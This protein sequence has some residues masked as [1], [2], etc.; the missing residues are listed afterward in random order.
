MNIS[1]E[2]SVG[3]DP[4]EPF[5]VQLLKVETNSKKDQVTF[6][7]IIKH[8]TGSIPEGTVVR[9]PFINTVNAKD[10]TK[11]PIWFDWKPES[12]LF[13]FT[14]EIQPSA[15]SDQV[16]EYL[17]ETVVETPD[18][19]ATLTFKTRMS[20][21]EL[22]P[23]VT[24]ISS[25]I[26]DEV[27]KVVLGVTRDDGRP[28]KRAWVDVSGPGVWHTWDSNLGELTVNIKMDKL[29]GNMV[30]VDVQFPV[31][32]EETK[33][34]TN[35]KVK[36]PVP[37]SRTIR[38][39]VVGGFI[40]K[41][42]LTFVANFRWG[43]TGKPPEKLSIP[44]TLKSATNVPSGSVKVSKVDYNPLTGDLRASIKVN[45]NNLIKMDY[46]LGML[47]TAD[48]FDPHFVSLL[49][50]IPPKQVK[51][52]IA[53][54]TPFFKGETINLPITV[55]SDETGLNVPISL[56][57]DYQRNAFTSRGLGDILSPSVKS[58]EGKTVL[59]WNVRQD[60]SR[61]VE[62]SAL[63]IYSFR[64]NDFLYDMKVVL[65][66]LAIDSIA[67]EI[68][69]ADV[70][71]TLILSRGYPIGTVKLAENKG[72]QYET[73][74]EHLGANV[75]KIT[76]RGAARTLR[77]VKK[78]LGGRLVFASDN[79]RSIIFSDEVE[80]FLK[81]GEGELTSTPVMSKLV[82]DNTLGVTTKLQWED[83][84]HPI[85][86]TM[87]NEVSTPNGRVL[88]KKWEYSSEE[89]NLTY[90]VDV[91]PSG[92]KDEF[93]FTALINTPDY[94]LPPMSVKTNVTI[95]SDFYPYLVSGVKSELL[96]GNRV[97]LSF[98]LRTPDGMPTAN[99]TDVVSV[100]EIYPHKGIR[101]Y[102]DFAF[103]N[104]AVT[105]TVELGKLDWS[106]SNYSL[107]I[108]FADTNVT[109]FSD[110]LATVEFKQEPKFEAELE[111]AGLAHP[112]LSGT[113]YTEICV[114]V[115]RHDLGE[116]KS[117][118]LGDVNIPGATLVS[119]RAVDE[120]KTF[121]IRIRLDDPLK[122]QVLEGALSLIV[123]QK[124]TL[125]LEFKEQYNVPGRAEFK[126][127]KIG[128]DLARP[129]E[130]TWVIGDWSSIPAE[131]ISMNQ[132][133]WKEQVNNL[134][135]EPVA[136]WN[137]VGNELT[138]KFPAVINRGKDMYYA[139]NNV[140]MLPTPDTTVYP[141]S[142][143]GV[144]ESSAP[145]EP[146]FSV[147]V[148]KKPVWDNATRSFEFTYDLK[149][150]RG[151]SVGVAKI[152]KINYLFGGEK[153]KVEPIDLVQIGDTLKLN[154][155]VGVDAEAI[156]FDIALSIEGAP[157]Q[158]ILRSGYAN[159]DNVGYTQQVYS[160]IIPKTDVLRIYWTNMGNELSDVIWTASK[161]VRLA[162]G[163]LAIDPVTNLVYGEFIVF[164]NDKQDV[165][166]KV[167]GISKDGV[168][169]E[170]DVIVYGINKP[171]NRLVLGTP[172]VQITDTEVVYVYPATYEGTQIGPEDV[173]GK[174][175]TQSG[176]FAGLTVSSNSVART[177][178]IKI[179]KYPPPHPVEFEV[180]LEVRSG[181]ANKPTT[182]KLKV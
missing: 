88:V 138:I 163:K 84:T 59:Q 67:T 44:L 173:S 6:H 21:L 172:K 100:E 148:T 156:L 111:Y 31:A 166:H 57:N 87:A 176:T 27:L 81:P 5:S 102:S 34:T 55:T 8:D 45:E 12:G 108:R 99:I 90:Y 119:M 136:S 41:G 142:F 58:V 15:N 65:K 9:T 154:Q 17:F 91:I 147:E 169:Y 125:T 30:D 134:P 13:A 94:G 40:E 72:S 143:D 97:R 86:V 157:N 128:D 69:T 181:K 98:G 130:V 120:L 32:V 149:N 14:M 89:G 70:V 182:L 151:N 104:G 124:N 26:T 152:E 127:M 144:I 24:R 37:R 53:Y 165:H 49:V 38:S 109:D 141:I 50:Q 77:P 121:A 73:E 122:S 132:R 46:E 25:S 22:G 170:A 159:T 179:V 10:K 39:R 75:V 36:S 19:T 112:V 4:N 35:V 64:G 33:T 114:G 7:A 47:V 158:V 62:F 106:G 161:D 79:C 177:L 123:D 18:N 145:Q 96:D 23:K 118:T 162:K 54:G 3:I 63:G 117:V 42:L 115:V 11:Y 66:S 92:M 131:Y 137:Q 105:M 164:L 116:S 113:R 140:F 155:K 153:A 146:K 171:Y 61:D 78:L 51:C 71:E 85:N 60:D 1:H 175:I 160:E 52:K 56:L 74:L 76:F 20:K 82:N 48:E 133:I 168:S 16:L 43:T 29:T 103:K 107:D 95:G 135:G 129:L 80:L 178:T 93:E 174:V 68:K 28:T 180:Q 167:R 126:S 2:S 101:N 110:K 83:G 150:T 139:G